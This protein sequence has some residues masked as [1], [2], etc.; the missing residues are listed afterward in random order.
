MERQKSS[1]MEILISSVAV[2]SA[3]ETVVREAYAMQ[4]QNFAPNVITYS[5]VISACE[6]SQ[7]SDKALELLQE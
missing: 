2:H 5:A 1:E 6:K 4:Q 3:Q 7:K